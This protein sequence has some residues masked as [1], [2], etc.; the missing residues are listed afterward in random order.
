MALAW[1]VGKGDVN[2]DSVGAPSGSSSEM[3]TPMREDNVSGLL[4][5]APPPRVV[6]ELGVVGVVGELGV[7]VAGWGVEGGGGRGRASVLLL[8]RKGRSATAA[9]SAERS[10]LGLDNEV[11]G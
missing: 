8:E 4:P 9:A 5:T 6:G 10:S 2:R 3:G 7:E 1:R 11:G